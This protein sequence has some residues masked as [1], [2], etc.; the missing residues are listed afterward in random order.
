MD[1]LEKNCKQ[2]DFAE[3]FEVIVPIKQTDSPWEYEQPL[4]SRPKVFSDNHPA[5]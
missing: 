3:S 1:S 5:E 4:K 2:P